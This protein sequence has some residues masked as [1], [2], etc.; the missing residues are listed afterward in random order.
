MLWN[1]NFFLLVQK[2][3]GFEYPRLFKNF[4]VHE[5]PVVINNK[6]CVLTKPKYRM[7]KIKFVDFS[8][9]FGI[10]CP[11]RVESD[12]ALCGIEND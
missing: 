2:P 5:K 4:F 10:K 9:T 12:M 6:K 8:P 7:R 1:F 3:L 11:N